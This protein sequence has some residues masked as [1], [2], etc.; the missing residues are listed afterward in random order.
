MKLDPKKKQVIDHLDGP[1]LVIAGPGAGKTTAMVER[2]VEM[3]KKGVRPENLFVSTFTEKAARE[4][5]S[6]ISDRLAEL[7]WLSPSFFC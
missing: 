5:V 1:L 4:L 6:R 2:I 7:I 3:I